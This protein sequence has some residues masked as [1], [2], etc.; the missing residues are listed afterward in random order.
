M[1]VLGLARNFLTIKSHVLNYNRGNNIMKQ[2][3]TLVSVW[4][5]RDLI[6]NLIYFVY[7]LSHEFPNDLRLRILEN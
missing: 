5:K 7:E 6:S 2:C 4:L 1:D 3:N